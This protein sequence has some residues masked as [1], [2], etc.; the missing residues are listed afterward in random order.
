MRSTPPGYTR[1]TASAQRVPGGDY[2][3]LLVEG[4]DVE[5]FQ[6][7]DPDGASNGDELPAWLIGDQLG[8][9]APQTTL[10]ADE[11]FHGSGWHT[12]QR[13]T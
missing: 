6:V 11:D 2:R 10:T 5:L 3:Q 1:S 8:D 9:I 13:I 4:E 7:I 12:G